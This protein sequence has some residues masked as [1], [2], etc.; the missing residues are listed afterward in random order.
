MKSG[1]TP[2]VYKTGSAFTS[3]CKQDDPN[4]FGVRLWQEIE[5]RNDQKTASVGLH[6]HSFAQEVKSNAIIFKLPLIIWR[7]SSCTDRYR[8]TLQLGRTR[9]TLDEAGADH[10]VTEIKQS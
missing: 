8:E 10:H 4:V 3:L 1:Q 6:T 9:L 7:S 5:T 2:A